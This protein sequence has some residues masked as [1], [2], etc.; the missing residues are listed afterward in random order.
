MTRRLIHPPFLLALGLLALPCAGEVVVKATSKPGRQ[1][2]DRPTTLLS[3]LPPVPE[4][5]GL[6]AFGGMPAKDTRATG[7]F[8]TRKIGSRWWLVTPQG[9]LFISRGVNSVSPVMTKAG[10]DALTA[11]FGTTAGWA[12]RTLDFLKE[13]GFNSLGAWADSASLAGSSVR[14]PQT[15]VWGFMSGYGK[16]RGGTRQDPG[17]TGY[18]NDC[19]FIFDPGFE[20]F[21]EQYAKKLDAM[22]DDPSIIGHYSDNE[23]PWSRKMLENYLSLPAS[24]PGHAAAAQWLDSRPGRSGGKPAITDSDRVDFLCFAM[25]RYL[26]ITSA[27]IRRH[28]PNHLFLGP[29]LH[30]AVTRI[31]EAFTALGGKVDVISV[32]Y[33]GAWTPEESLVEMWSSRSGKPVLISEFYAKA[34]NSGMANTGGAG[35]LVKTQKDRGAFYQNFTLGLIRSRVCIGWHWHRYADNDPDDKR[36][37]PSNRDSNK[38]IVTNRYDPFPELLDAMRAVNLRTCGLADRFDSVKP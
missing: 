36:L 19:P 18:P 16:L 6:D 8:H 4:D 3:D 34:E 31:P 11:K 10:K 27:A 28:A 20:P 7:Y 38:G 15:V 33:Y 2:H 25:G 1:W 32:N 23:L 9:G 26:A 35:W 5:K 17:H 24:D 14:L 13:N 29:R 22:R 37:D 21:C 30:G 12:D